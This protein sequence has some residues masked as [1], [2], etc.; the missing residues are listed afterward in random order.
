MS[1]KGELNVISY[2]SRILTIKGQKFSTTYREVIGIVYSLRVYEHINIGSEHFSNI[3][4]HQRPILSQFTEKGTF[5]PISNTARLQ[6]TK[7][8]KL[9]IVYRKG[10][11]SFCS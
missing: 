1:S 2:N 5:S 7:F 11:K 3:V 6:L 4:N 10:K 8:Q 9:R